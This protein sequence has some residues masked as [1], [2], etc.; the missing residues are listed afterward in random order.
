MMEIATQAHHINAV[1]E[2]CG[3]C[4]GLINDYVTYGENVRSV[5]CGGIAAFGT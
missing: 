1:A 2:R 4:P 3:G 5:S